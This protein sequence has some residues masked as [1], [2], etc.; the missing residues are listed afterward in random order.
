MENMSGRIISTAYLDLT[1]SEW[2]VLGTMDEGKVCQN[3]RFFLSCCILQAVSVSFQGGF[4]LRVLWAFTGPGFLMSIAYLDPGNIESD[5]QSGTI[6]QYKV[7]R[8]H[9]VKT[10]YMS[11]TSTIT[12]TCYTRKK[13]AHRKNSIRESRHGTVL[14]Q[15]TTFLYLQE[16]I[17]HKF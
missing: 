6:A 17:I 9:L 14:H 10:V 1:Y 15:H 16:S 4:S 3:C 2:V 5:L 7:M 8:L 12:K 13:F 11:S